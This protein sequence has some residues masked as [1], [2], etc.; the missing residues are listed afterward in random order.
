MNV[1]ILLSGSSNRFFKKN[2]KVPK[3]LI[4]IN[5]KTILEYI[6]SNFDTKK[7]NFLT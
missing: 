2:Y 3:F 6:I 1:V 7:D 5:K 4:T